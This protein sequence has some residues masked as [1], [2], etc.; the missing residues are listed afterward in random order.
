MKKISKLILLPLLFIFVGAFLGCSKISSYQKSIYDDNSKI[1][2]AGDSYSF[3]NR[4]GNTMN[5]KAT[6]NFTTFYGMQTLWNIQSEGNGRITIQ[7]YSNTKKGKFKVVYIDPNN[8]I[9]NILQQSGEGTIKIDTKKGK[10][11][12]KLVGDNGGG[13]VK[14]NLEAQGDVRIEN[15]D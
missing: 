5:N 10:S 15:I 14:L 7:Y 8:E 12:I 2:K 11:R 3:K 6:I 13:T 9:E 1:A 4:V